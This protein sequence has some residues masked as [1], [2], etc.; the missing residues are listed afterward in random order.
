MDERRMPNSPKMAISFSV[1]TLL[2]A[3]IVLWGASS[4]L[5]Q[6]TAT[7][8][9]MTVDPT[10]RPMPG[11]QVIVRQPATGLVRVAVTGID[12]RFVVAG[13]PAG[14]YQLRA[15]VPGFRPVERTGIV[16]TVGEV[17]SIGTL[18]LE[19]GGITEAVVVTSTGSLVNTQT[20]ELSYLVGEQVV[21]S[22]PLNGR[23][24]T[25]LALLQPGVLPYPS[26]DGG[27]V[28]AHGLG[29]S[30]NGQDYRSNVYLLDGTLLNDFTNGPAGS[31]AGTTLGVESVQEFRVEANAYSA[32]YGRNF[33]GQINVVTKSGTNELRGSAYEFHRN[34]ALDA[35]NY[36]DIAGKPDFARN[37]F[38]G[39][40]GG[41]VVRDRLFYF[42]GYEALRENLGKTISAFVPDDDARAGLLP[43]GPVTINSA[44][45]PYLDAIP[46]ANGPAIGSGLATHT[47]TFD[48][49][50]DQ[51]FF[52]GRVDYQMHANHQFFGRYT[53]DDVE[54]WLPTEYPQ[55]PRAFI[56]TNQFA[57]FEYRNVIS[58]RMFQTVR[59]GYSRTRIGQNVEANLDSPLPP[60]VPGRAIVGDIDIAGQRF[61]P[62]VSA[63]LRLAQNVYSGQWDLT[64][65]RGRH[66]I[67]T[68][69]VVERY[70]D[71]MTNP[72]FSLGIYAFANVRTFLENRPLRFVGLGP[73][74]DIN[75]DWPWT[76][77][78]AFAQDHY[79]LTPNLS[80]NA[81][82]RYESTTMPVDTGGRD[83]ALVDLADPAP[84]VGRL[85]ENPSSFNLSPRF[86]AA[87]DVL[88]DGSTSVRGGYGLY[89]NTNNQQN[90][91]VTVTNPPATPRF[92]IPNPT[93]PNPP[94]ERGIGNTIRPMQYDIQAPR[95]HMWN[96]SVQR[97]L[98]ASLVA[99]VG[100]AGSRGKHLFRNTDINIPTPT[101]NEDGRLFF[102]AGLP[103][104]NPAFGTIELK[105]SDGNSWYKALIVELRRTFS[106]GLAVQSSYTWSSTEDTTQASTFFSDATNG[107]TVAFP[108]FDPDYNKGPADWD[109]RHNWVLNVIW[110]V[111]FARG[112][113]GLAGALLDGWQLSG[114]STV[115]SGQPLTVFVQSNWSRSQ[116]SPSIAPN[117]GLDRP[118]LAPGRTPESAVL[119]DPDQWFDP[120]AFVLQP[121][122]TLGNSGRG[123]FRGPNLRT[124]DIAAVKAVPLGRTARLD[125]RIEVFNLFN[126]A[127]FGNP[128]LLA[129]AGN[130]ANEAPFATF[131]RIRSTI[132]SA[133]QM[134][135]GARLSF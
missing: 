94:F 115:R 2:A 121:Q 47:W 104:P 106:Q 82:L 55:F 84:T 22:L 50:V 124:F 86:G 76:Y 122:G 113:S 28:V 80:L 41:P 133:R 49:T 53:F 27:S 109:T 99:T 26:R 10:A 25:D 83:S 16:V 43:D 57:T 61:G 93:F 123:A 23:N 66:L 108:E 101:P 20:S 88:G 119:G 77:V 116:W 59:F 58:S 5:A 35:A 100:Y 98:P 46:R 19:I 126:R 129:F 11:V 81:G 67:K 135:L 73:E 56:S 42:F 44:V 110:D 92:V 31:A 105:S 33:G 21:S 1:R 6:T 134:Q 128:T 29:M 131:G 102:A 118:D 34:D 8:A 75:R 72:T 85:S 63:N 13:L 18:T 39:A 95:L 38:G 30:V 12:G 125:L 7:L 48:Q 17:V 14:Q 127:N 87:W 103:R 74:G 70:R 89:F 112:K 91:I 114:I 64:H 45:R 32:E 3:T 90:L 97:T 51:T 15:E 69:V 9:G 71:F 132:T 37:Q 79:Q 68:G 40:V 60:F 130:A 54:Q 65:T 24:Y 120:T 107:T 52:Q 62:Q 4:V 111:P 117:T 78:A 96:V 36:F